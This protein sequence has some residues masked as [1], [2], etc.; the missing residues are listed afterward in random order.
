MESYTLKIGENKSKRFNWHHKQS[1][2]LNE[3]NELF[4]ETRFGN[5]HAGFEK[6]Q[7]I[8]EESICPSEPWKRDVSLSTGRK[9]ISG[10]WR[11][12]RLALSS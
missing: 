8:I 5:R 3:Q 1:Y 2:D 9:A 7:K 12:C 11:P 6:Y 10:C 4:L